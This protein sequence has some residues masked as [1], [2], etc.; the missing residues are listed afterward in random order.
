MAEQLLPCPFCGAAFKMGQE[1]ND[2]GY[3]AGMFYIFHDYGPIGSAARSCIIDVP[4]HF[5][6]EEAAIIAWNARHA[7]EGYNP[8]AVRD[9][10]EAAKGALNF[11]QNTESELGEPLD[12]G[13]ALR[14]ALARLE[15]GAS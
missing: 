1:P 15:G 14:A 12:S 8:D 3:V 10:V 6:T 2:N 4:K 7:L 11:I 13:D 9:V 5:K